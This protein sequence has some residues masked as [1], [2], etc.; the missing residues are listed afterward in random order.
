MEVQG[1]NGSNWTKIF[2]LW[3]QPKGRVLKAESVQYRFARVVWL[4]YKQIDNLSSLLFIR[5]WTRLGRF[6]RVHL[7]IHYSTTC[8]ATE[9]RKVACETVNLHTFWNIYCRINQNAE[10]VSMDLFPTFEITNSSTAAVLKTLSK[11]KLWKLLG[12]RL[13]TW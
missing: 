9:C 5:F 1:K 10:V 13:Q 4:H 3:A 6:K 7:L 12:L 11:T 2:H 8:G